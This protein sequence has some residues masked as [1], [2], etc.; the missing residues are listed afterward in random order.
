MSTLITI[1]ATTRSQIPILDGFDTEDGVTIEL[2]RPLVQEVA[3]GIDPTTLSDKDLRAAIVT[4]AYIGVSSH[5]FVDELIWREGKSQSLWIDNRVNPN[6]EKAIYNEIA[7]LYTG[8]Q[9]AITR[10]DKNVDHECSKLA[11]R[12]ALRMLKYA[13]EKG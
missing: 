1:S 4:A 9:D 10:C 12:G 5:A 2:D 6:I 3:V 8:E 11:E 13:H 7:A